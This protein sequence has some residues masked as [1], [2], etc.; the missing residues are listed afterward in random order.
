VGGTQAVSRGERSVNALLTRL[1]A[2]HDAAV[3][4]SGITPALAARLVAAQFPQWADLPVRDVD[5]KGHD[6]VTFRLGDHLSVRMPSGDNYVPQVGKEHRWLPELARH[7]PL[8]IPE[9]VARGV[10][11]C[12]YPW[13]WSVYRWLDGEPAATAQVGDLVRFA[14][15]LAGFL[16]ALYRVDTSGGPPAGSDTC[17]FGAPLA[18]WDSQTRHALAALDGQIDTRRATEAWETALAATRPG[19][20]VWFHGDI[21][22]GNLLVSRDR[23]TAVIDFGIAGVGDPACDT[24]IAWTFFSGESREAYRS[25]LAVDEAAWTRGRGWA[26]WKALITLARVVDE[27]PGAAARSRRVIHEVL[28]PPRP[29]LS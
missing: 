26:L 19:P 24:A 20:A 15:D 4:R 29:G 9:P 2:G 6:N 3:D 16:N 5:L 7:L 25:L 27:D 1:A 18:H 12:G 22:P 17:Y 23:L 21:A 10:P 28:Q 13:P 8:R 11:G 14:A